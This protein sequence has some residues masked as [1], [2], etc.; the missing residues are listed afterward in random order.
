MNS[1]NLTVALLELSGYA[2]DFNDSRAKNT[3]L[4]VQKILKYPF[5]IVDTGS[6][7]QRT[8]N[9]LNAYYNAGKRIFL[10]FGR[11]T[12]LNQVR[13]W[14]VAHPD[15]IAISL[16]STAPSLSIPDNIVRLAPNDNKSVEV[17]KSIIPR[18]DSVFLL[19]EQ[20][21]LA[22]LELSR[23]LAPYVDYILFT[24][25]S[26]NEGKK[27]LKDIL[28]MAVSLSRTNKVLL[29]PQ[30]V[31]Q[32]DIF[33]SLVCSY[34]NNNIHI[35]DNIGIET[36]NVVDE[37][38]FFN[39]RYHFIS[40]YASMTPLLRDLYRSLGDEFSTYGYDA[41]LLAKTLDTLSKE[42]NVSVSSLIP[43]ISYINGASGSL[44]LDENGDRRVSSFLVYR[45][46]NNQWIPDE[47]FV[48]DPQL[49][50]YSAKV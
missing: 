39:E 17:F 50:N 49:G 19:V 13:G 30:I 41:V 25:L 23:M 9:L 6:D 42:R 21:E 10:G 33:R 24:D 44:E 7:I 46:Y 20:G 16:T 47:I 28:S 45:L 11:S 48:N 12:V 26:T 8:I 32:G 5:P 40:A 34:M 36:L 43:Y 31:T 3:F 22:A 38:R 35:L 29:I 15:T 14:F 37:C 2:A 4:L 27:E 1:E 18:Y